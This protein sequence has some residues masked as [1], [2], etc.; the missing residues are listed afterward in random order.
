MPRHIFF[1]LV[2]GL[3]LVRVGA[4]SFDAIAGM[5]LL[6]DLHLVGVIGSAVA[7]NALGLWWLRRGQIRSREGAPLALATKPLVPGLAVG[8]LLFGAGWAL[9]G[10]CPGTALAQ[11]G[12]GKL[13]GLVTFAG[14]VAG[15]WLQSWRATPARAT[16]ARA[17]PPE[18]AATSP[19]R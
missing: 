17:T 1:G 15:A 13:A 11:I 14:I 8:A 9:S 12:E 6:S 2:F 16:P 10:T 19:A 3:V 7:L 18:G 5:F 4:T